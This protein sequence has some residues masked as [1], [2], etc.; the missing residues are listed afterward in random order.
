MVSLACA[1]GTV[2]YSIPIVVLLAASC[3]RASPLWKLSLAIPLAVASDLLLLLLAAKAMRLEVAVLASRVAWLVVG[4]AWI[5]WAR[6]RAG[7]WPARPRALRAREMAALVLAASGAVVLSLQLSRPFHIWDRHWHIPLA[8]VLR[9]QRLPFHNTF[10]PNAILHY[11]LTGD[12]LGATFQ[13]LSFGVI[14]SSLALSLAH[15]VIFA[16]IAASAALAMLAAGHRGVWPPVLGALALLLQGPSALRGE[17]PQLPFVGHSV[18]TFEVVSFRPHA[19]L[20]ALLLVGIVV[21]VAAQLRGG[22]ATHRLATVTLLVCGAGLAVTDESSL[23]IVGLA[24]GSAWI[25]EPNVLAPRRAEGLLILFGLGLAAIAANVAFHGALMP[26][27]PVSEIHR[28]APRAPGL[29]KRVGPIPLATPE[30]RAALFW[31]VLPFALC[32]FGL[33]LRAL[34]GRRAFGAIVLACVTL[35]VSLVLLTCTEIQKTH[36]ESVRFMFA[37]GFVVLLLALLWVHEAPAGSLAQVA[38]VG[39]LAVGALSTVSW[40]RCRITEINYEAVPI[41][42]VDLYE[43]DCRRDA[44]ARLGERAQVVYFDTSIGGIEHG[45]HPDY[46]AGLAD[47]EWRIKLVPTL[48]SSQLRQLDHEMVASGSD[49]AVICPAEG[50]DSVCTEAARRGRCEPRGRLLRRCVLSAKDRKEVL[51]ERSP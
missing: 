51:G 11:H 31:D 40:M 6:L 39:G 35:A 49:L 9:A 12:V 3:A 50:G 1:L 47:P 10:E 20:A 27:G 4:A 29:Y 28:V 14:N 41:Q 16:L 19:V 21:S 15:D 32:A 5:A 22:P 42:S 38:I 7:T 33:T 43:V 44:G 34:T 37:Q 18:E 46:L 25:V 45:C 26:G 23:A 36:E 24:L 13:I 30:G 48:D 8:S 2:L 17:P